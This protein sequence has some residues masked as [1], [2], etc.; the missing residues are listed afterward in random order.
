MVDIRHSFESHLFHIFTPTPLLAHCTCPCEVDDAIVL[1]KEVHL[2]DNRNI[3][4]Q[5][6]YQC[7]NLSDNTFCGT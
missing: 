3:S 2:I 5:H 1:L 7:L 6:F 4:Y